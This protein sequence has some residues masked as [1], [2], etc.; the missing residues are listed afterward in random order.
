MTTNIPLVWVQ[1]QDLDLNLIYKEGETSEFTTPIDLSNGYSV[2]MDIVG[3]KGNRL[4]TF[5]SDDIVDVDLLTDGDQADDT[6]EAVLGTGNAGQPNI[7]VS[8]SRSLTLPGGP[9]YASI[10]GTPPVLTFYSDI[11]LRDTLSDKQWKI[12]TITITL[13]KSYTLWS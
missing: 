1:G 6:T 5:N 10:T 7:A 11:F 9:L 8:V 12:V 3:G 13:E 4:Y 2:R